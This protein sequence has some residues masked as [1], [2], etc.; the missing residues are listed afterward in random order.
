M[1]LYAPVSSASSPCCCACCTPTHSSQHSRRGGGTVARLEPI[2]RTLIAGGSVPLPDYWGGM[3]DL[4]QVASPPPQS[5][6]QCVC[7]AHPVCGLRAG[8]T[9]GSC[10]DVS[11][12]NRGGRVAA[13]MFT[14]QSRICINHRCALFLLTIALSF[15]ASGVYH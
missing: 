3:N 13:N 9:A 4:A 8:C 1:R 14:L 2:G 7:L 12:G 15:F 11:K 6:P 5:T 10:T